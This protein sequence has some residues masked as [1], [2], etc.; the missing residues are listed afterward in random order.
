MYLQLTKYLDTDLLLDKEEVRL[1][2]VG[3]AILTAGIDVTKTLLDSIIDLERGGGCS[4]HFH[5]SLFSQNSF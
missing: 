1:D 5:G 3:K 4:R 2:W